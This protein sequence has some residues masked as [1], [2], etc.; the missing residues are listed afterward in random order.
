MS[1][2]NTTNAKSPLDLP[3]IQLRK[4]RPRHMDLKDLESGKITHPGQGVARVLE[5]AGAIVWDSPK[6]TY[7]LTRRG[8]KLLHEWSNISSKDLI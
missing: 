5:S 8:R 6:N 7:R 1:E 2:K 3:D 4:T